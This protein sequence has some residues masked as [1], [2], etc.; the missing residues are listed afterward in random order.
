[1]P[2]ANRRCSRPAVLLCLLISFT[3]STA[4][5][6]VAQDQ[7]AALQQLTQSLIALGDRPAGEQ[8]SARDL[9]RARYDLL[10]AL[11][12]TSPRAVPQFFL[13]PGTA[14]KL[15]A[16]AQPY[17]E[18]DA[19]ETGTL[20]AL[21]EDYADSHKLR[22]FLDTGAEN[23]ELYFAAGAPAH[24]LTGSRIRVRGK[25]LD[26]VLLLGATATV[27]LTSAGN[28]TSDDVEV[29]SLATPNTFGEQST[30]VLLVNFIDN[31]S[32]PFSFDDMR[33]LVFNTVSNF[34]RENSQNQT[35]LTGDVFGWFTVPI[36]VTT[37]PSDTSL[38]SAA[39]SAAADVGVDLSP[40]SRRVYMFPHTACVWEGLATIGG[41]PSHALINGTPALNVVGHEMGH[42]FGLYHSHSLEC[43][44]TTIGGDCQQVEY[45]DRFDIMGHFTT[46]H[47]NA[48]QKE[49]LGWLNYGSSLP[50]TTVTSSGTYTLTPYET[51][52]GVKALKMVQSTDPSTGLHTWYY[53]EYRQL[54][55]FDSALSVYPTSVTGVVIHSGAEEN[56]NS[57]LLLNTNPQDASFAT[58]ALQPG[59]TFTDTGAYVS[60]TTKSAD[61]NGATV[62][63][64]IG[65][66][67]GGCKHSAPGLTITPSL[68]P[69]VRAGATQNFSVSVTNQD[70]TACSAASFLLTLVSPASPPS[71]TASISPS[72]VTLLPLASTTAVLQVTSPL[73]APVGN[74]QITVNATEWPFFTY[75]SSST[76]TYV[77]SNSPPPDFTLAAPASVTVQQKSSANASV[78]TT[79]NNGFSA[80]ISLSISGLP[81]GVTAVFSPSG[82]A[83]PGSGTSTLT[84]SAAASAAVGTSTATVTASGGGITHTTAMQVSV[85]SAPPVFLTSITVTPANTSISAGTTQQFTATGHYS[86]GSTQDLTSQVAWSSSNTT[87]ATIS[88]SGLA[89][90]VLAGT[91]TIAAAQSG[92]SGSTS[93]TVTSTPPPPP[94]PPPPPASLFSANAVPANSTRIGIALELGMKFTADSSGSITGIR[95]YKTLYDNATHTGSLWTAGGEKL[96]SV[97]FGN[98]SASGWQQANLS[99]PVA[100][101]ANTVYLVSYSSPNGVF[102]Y[103]DDFFNSS[104]DNPPLHAPASATV[105][106]NGAFAYGVGIFPIWSNY[107]RNY[108]VDVVFAGSGG[109]PPSLTS[110]TV[111]PANP[112][113][114][115]GTTQQ[116]TAAGK[117][118]DGSTKGLTSQVAWSSSKTAVA[119]ISSSGLATAVAA[120]TTTITA[121][122]NSISGSTSLTVT[123]TPPPPPPPPSSGYSLFSAS[124]VPANSTRISIALELGM[125][126]TADR[127]GSITGIRFYK[128]LY[129]NAPH[130]GSLWT[131][132]GEKLASVTFTNETASGWQQANFSTPVAIAA[133]TVYLVSY[134]S[135]NGAFSYT[136]DFFN[137]S[138]DNPPLHAPASAAV[139]GN[140]VF[141]YGAG[142]FPIWTNYARNYWVDV[143][144]Q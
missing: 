79:V 75:V 12:A 56:G 143:V 97:T 25:R 78:T 4:L 80:P 53:L 47:F 121:A 105:N 22:F 136:D 108:W 16:S 131:A 103:T 64:E 59:E 122:Q 71:W 27:P 9:A 60:I 104:V 36:S 85:T 2:S 70:T 28:T 43:Q 88:G 57:S 142:L 46:A 1:M 93:L 34:D 54:I 63:I 126:F 140:G 6:Q 37:C 95:F 20:R 96:A 61:A 111:T 89:T 15:P 40:Y 92:I 139:N 83:A 35:W 94:P 10:L 72:Y 102:S 99:T 144:F 73:T 91:T 76:A 67:A 135:P 130:T 81:A 39:D 106:G 14:S 50:I 7:L 66:G 118:S 29:L 112:S 62:D 110:I 17:L 109:A 42:N 120:G 134:S 116:F 8:F 137:L 101:T 90:G 119:T 30:A 123:T 132:G 45:G 32:Q 5:A 138:V 13:P 124:A 41:N 129:D 11:A 127:S 128:T 44:G 49:R 55:G 82:F 100:I 74:Y 51:G 87:V 24:L 48:F 68:G 141:A 31:T 77:V 26:N 86:D 69:P 133:N 84:V 3:A 19:D 98:E 125:K 117:Y 107:A 114:S 58:A 52:S 113:I 115:A 21:V 65:P 33:N 38:T 18:T 23:L